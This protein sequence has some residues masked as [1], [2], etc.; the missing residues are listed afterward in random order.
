MNAKTG[1]HFVGDKLRD[2]QPV[3]P[4]GVWLV[5]EG[6]I[7]MCKSGLHLSRKPF[8]ALQYAPGATLCRVLYGGEVIEDEDK[9][10]CTR[11]KIIA[12]FDATELLRTFARSEALSVIHLWN[13]PDVVVRYLKTGDQSLRAAARDAAWD[14][15]RSVIE[16]DFN[17]QLEAMVNEGHEAQE[18]KE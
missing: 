12:R 13:A 7:K 9:V 8:D 16:S 5:H 11:R 1:Y 2:G 4:D 18:D 14:A 3:P 15:A 10:V 6:P 17:A